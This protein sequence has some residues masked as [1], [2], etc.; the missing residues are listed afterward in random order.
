MRY[1]LVP[2]VND[3]TFSFLAIWLCLPVGLL[4]SLLILWFCFLLSRDSEENDREFRFNW[5]AWRKS[6][7]EALRIQQEEERRAW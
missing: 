3:L 7:E 6:W 4:L 1:P 5:E 2:L